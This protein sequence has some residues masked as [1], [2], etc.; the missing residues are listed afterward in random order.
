M[1][2]LMWFTIGFSVGCAIGAYLFRGFWLLLLSF[3]FAFIALMTLVGTSEKSEITRLIFSGCSLAL[4]WVCLFHWIY[5]SPVKAVDGETVTATIE[6][7]DY[8]TQTEWGISADGK[9]MDEE[10]I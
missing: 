6:I 5:L 2:K 10:I 1:R 3:I 8:H 9:I 4:V 7:T